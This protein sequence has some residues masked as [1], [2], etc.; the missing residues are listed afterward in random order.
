MRSRGKVETR[1][2]CLHVC[3]SVNPSVHDEK[4]NEVMD[5]KGGMRSVLP[6]HSRPL[7]APTQGP[8]KMMEQGN[9]ERDV[10]VR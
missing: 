5:G 2:A 4:W 3:V 7:K 8:P 9:A 6:T 1:N 10:G